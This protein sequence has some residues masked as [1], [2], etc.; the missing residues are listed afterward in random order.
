M[1]M[2]KILLRCIDWHRRSRPDF[3]ADFIISTLTMLNNIKKIA[4]F[5]KLLQRIGSSFGRKNS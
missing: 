3:Y 1:N 4:A 5:S 2:V